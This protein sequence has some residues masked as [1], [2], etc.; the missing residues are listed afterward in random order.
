MLM[1]QCP[2]KNRAQLCRESSGE[3]HGRGN[4]EEIRRLQQLPPQ[5]KW[6]LK[7]D[8]SYAELLACL[9]LLQGTQLKSAVGTERKAVGPARSVRAL[10]MWNSAASWDICAF[11]STLVVQTSA[12]DCIAINC[13]W[14]ARRAPHHGGI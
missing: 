7:A 1:P 14:L 6:G 9:Y 13:A 11:V 12:M 10:E 8:I 5:R 3:A 4:V 2:P